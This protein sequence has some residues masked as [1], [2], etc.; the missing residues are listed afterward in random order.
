[1]KEKGW[2]ACLF[3]CSDFHQSEYIGGYFQ[4]LQYPS[5][6]SGDAETFKKEYL[7][8]GEGGLSQADINEYTG[9]KKEE[10]LTE[11]Q[12]AAGGLFKLPKN[13]QMAKT[14]DEFLMLLCKLDARVSDAMQRV[15]MVK[16]CKNMAKQL[17]ANPSA[18]NEYE[19]SV[20]QVNEVRG[21][22]VRLMEK[23][24]ISDVDV[25]LEVGGKGCGLDAF[26]G[27]VLPAMIR[28]AVVNVND[29]AD[30]NDPQ[31]VDEL[32]D[33]M[34]SVDK[35]FD[36]LKSFMAGAKKAVEN[37]KAEDAA[38]LANNVNAS[39]ENANFTNARLD[40][41]SV[42][43][44]AVASKIEFRQRGVATKLVA[45]MQK[46]MTLPLIKEVAV[47]NFAIKFVKDTFSAVAPDKVAKEVDKNG[48]P[49]NGGIVERAQDVANNIKIAA[50]LVWGVK[51]DKSANFEE[52][53]SGTV[54]SESV[55]KF[56]VEVEKKAVTLVNS[57]KGG[58]KLYQRLLAGPVSNMLNAKIAAAKAGGIAS[59]VNI[60]E[61]SYQEVFDQMEAARDAWKTFVYN[62]ADDII[63][64]GRGAFNSY[65]NHLVKKGNISLEDKTRLLSDYHSRMLGAVKN[66][67][68]RFFYEKTPLPLTYGN[69]VKDMA[70][71][72]LETLMSLFAAERSGVMSELKERIAV[73]VATD[74]IPVAKRNVIFDIPA[75][76]KDCRE[77]IPQ[78]IAKLKAKCDV[79][80]GAINVAISRMWYGVLAERFAD[81]KVR[82]DANY[83]Y[84]D[85]IRRSQSALVDR[86]KKFI[87]NYIAVSA[88]ID[89]KVSASALWSVKNELFT[90]DFLAYY[91]AELKSG[92]FDA[93]CESIRDDVLGAKKPVV[94]AIKRRF[95]E[96]PDVY[97]K[98]DITDESIDNEL[99][100]VYGSDYRNSQNNRFALYSKILVT[101]ARTFKTW[102]A[103]A[104]GQPDGAISL[105]T[106]L[107][108]SFGRHLTALNAE[109]DNEAI[110]AAAKDI[111]E[112]ER[113]NI[114]SQA[115]KEVL[116]AADRYALSYMRGGHAAFLKRVT[117]EI[118]ERVDS[119]ILAYSKFREEFVKL[120][121]PVMEK[122]PALGREKLEQKLASVLRDQSKLTAFPKAKPLAV[123]FDAALSKMVKDHVDM[124]EAEFREYSA[125][126]SQTYEKC[127]K[128]FNEKV[129]SMEGGLRAAGA[130][131]EDIAY[132]RN[133]LMPAMRSELDADIQQNP[134]SYFRT[135]K[136]VDFGIRLAE[137]KADIIIGNMETALSHMN[138]STKEGMTF[139]I[140]DAGFREFAVD[141]EAFEISKRA[142]DTWMKG[143]EAKNIV[144]NARR[145]RMLLAAKSYTMSGADVAEAT[146][147][148]EAFKA[149]M[150]KVLIGLRAV[151][152]AQDFN[153]NQVGPAVELFK[154]WLSRYDLPDI[155]VAT[156]EYGTGS[157]KDL[158]VRH[159]QRHVVELQ[160]KI[161][162]SEDA[163]LGGE[164]LL[165]PEYVQ[166]LVT[167]INTV[168][169][170]AV[171]ASK[172]ADMIRKHRDEI[173]NRIENKDVYDVSDT[174][175]LKYEG[176]TVKQMNNYGLVNALVKM[177]D[178]AKISVRETITSMEDLA[179]WG[180]I[181]DRN[182]EQAIA[183]NKEFFDNY[184]DFAF[185]RVKMM[186]IIDVEADN[187][188]VDALMRAAFKDHF[189]ADIL[190]E[191]GGSLLSEK[192]MRKYGA[193]F[194]A[195]VDG[196][197]KE[198]Y[199][200]VAERVKVLKGMALTVPQ[201]GDRLDNLPINGVSDGY[202]KYD[203]LT[204]TIGGFVKSVV[205]A[206]S[207]SVDKATKSMYKAIEADVAAQAKAA[208]KAK[209]AQA[210][211]EQEK[212]G[213]G[214]Y[215]ESDMGSGSVVDESILFGGGYMAIDSIDSI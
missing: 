61:D 122:Y 68:E 129:A 104:N 214:G 24:G 134:D 190:D 215:Y 27:T 22:I 15:K 65:L 157:I 50:Q 164:T 168:G 90:K 108:A 87:D 173:V 155:T 145:G 25:G 148:V 193:E 83:D 138:L 137:I 92:E 99:F 30:K 191:K 48:V 126:I 106:D 2:D 110:V 41:Y 64:D 85:F 204:D 20:A 111:T 72:G 31:S 55:G 71:A 19:N 213:R 167:F 150:R 40:V 166:S 26:L 199:K 212:A 58:V 121:Q 107:F 175:D 44:N 208:Q 205:K 29:F 187:A 200:D 88:K 86:V 100:A 177:L 140:Y 112:A 4:S 210:K 21:A 125:K 39:R 91:K 70:K 149:G 151:D 203:L 144:A 57:V 14:E 131:D 156:A 184:V 127:V 153:E 178:V 33:S 161:V 195:F 78:Y 101:R 158:A 169:L 197:R 123:A 186:R 159:F 163:S 209:A 77:S 11:E 51:S 115:I 32:L 147:N 198:C 97:K 202:E 160:R 84:D 206:K 120:A 73:M 103:H 133:T 180:D 181:V 142:L 95:F 34:L 18:F 194:N 79:D 189:K 165:S 5:G 109:K 172:Q 53:A 43:V 162:D 192:F 38:E 9:Y 132:L 94:D 8:L 185:R 66:A 136:G 174:G 143:D 171:F 188:H 211:A 113:G 49:V 37:V 139:A 201:P 10:A 16:V 46:K 3:V 117:K 63:A 102:L 6:F 119:R 75:R 35:I 82:Y 47:E 80:D 89:E 96:H 146:R 69:T 28:Q 93:V 42:A 13:E 179:R 124:E 154:S 105:A 17:I 62:R 114:V 141:E 196:I 152:N 60:K 128:A 207:R 56:L 67:V 116:E 23:E 76:V 183:D 118:R 36:T 182:F 170:E 176:M 1:M 74:K 135:A 12:K 52:K 98:K 45:D 54:Y 81:K 59:E 130:T 7:R